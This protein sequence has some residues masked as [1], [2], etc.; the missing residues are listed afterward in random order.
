MVWFNVFVFGVA[1]MFAGKAKRVTKA[2]RIVSMNL[3]WT[4]RYSEQKC[5][6][7]TIDNEIS[8][9]ARSLWLD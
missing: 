9:I 8:A 6:Y 1:E 7:N 4:K 3:W 5:V 2:S